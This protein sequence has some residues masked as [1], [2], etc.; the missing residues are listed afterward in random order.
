[1]V[2]VKDRIFIYP[3][4][5]IKE[6]KYLIEAESEEQAQ[7]MI[8]DLESGTLKSPDDDMEILEEIGL[9]TDE[10]TKIFRFKDY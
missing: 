9:H 8:E 5:V 7:R 10:R 1:M 4:P 6:K 2:R 3:V